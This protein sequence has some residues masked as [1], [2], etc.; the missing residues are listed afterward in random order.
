MS[1]IVRIKSE[2]LEAR[3]NKNSVKAILL[4]TLIGEADTLAKNEGTTLLADDKVIALVK[5][6]L[7]GINET[8][9]VVDPN[10]AADIQKEKEILTAYLPQQMSR[11]ALAAAIMAIKN[12]IPGYTSKD[13]GKVMAAL[14]AN[15]DGAYD[16]KMASEIAKS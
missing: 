15:Y 13:M 4:T 16:A 12:E 11:E 10:A 14:K 9:A 8:L 2:Q 5:K 6:F 3:K 7:K 1:L